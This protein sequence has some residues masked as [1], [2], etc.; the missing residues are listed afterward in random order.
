MARKNPFDLGSDF[1]IDRESPRLTGRGIPWTAARVPLHSHFSCRRR[2][3][4]ASQRMVFRCERSSLEMTSKFRQ[5]LRFFI[6]KCYSCGWNSMK[7]LIEMKIFYQI[8][9]TI[10]ITTIEFDAPNFV[11][12]KATIA[13]SIFSTKLAV[14]AHLEIRWDSMRFDRCNF[15][16]A[17]SLMNTHQPA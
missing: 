2:Y 16:D 9:L 12:A 14:S 13:F 1:R 7:Y 4:S 8:K 10:R 3:D 6:W 5:I 15:D 17:N 11:Q